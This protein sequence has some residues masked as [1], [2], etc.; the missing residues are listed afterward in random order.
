MLELLGC[1]GIPGHGTPDINSGT[2]PGI[3]GRLATLQQA[4]ISDLPS[5]D[6][7]VPQKLPLW[8]N[9]DDVISCDLWF[10]PPPTKNFG[11]ANELEIA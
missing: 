10:R 7:F 1:Q 11:Y 5:Y 4:T 6:I 3:P 8:Q 9:F 2:V